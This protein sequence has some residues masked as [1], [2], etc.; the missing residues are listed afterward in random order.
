MLTLEGKVKCKM[1]I[2]F[3][4]IQTDVFVLWIHFHNEICV[5]RNSPDEEC[6]CSTKPIRF[7]DCIMNKIIIMRG[8][9]DQIS[10]IY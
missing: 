1:K 4:N 5:Q 8:T 10:N 9:V 6:F 7:E 2:L 3:T